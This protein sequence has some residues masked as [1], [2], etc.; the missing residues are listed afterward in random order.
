M[1]FINCLFIYKKKPSEKFG[2]RMKK[3]VEDRLKFLGN[4][5]KTAKNIDAMEEV[6]NELKS[7]GLYVDSQKKKKSKKNK[8]KKKSIS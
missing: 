1:K 7:E 8:N 5:E 2:D 3:Q 6:L 4:G